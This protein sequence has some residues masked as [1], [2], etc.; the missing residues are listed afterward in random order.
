MNRVGHL[1]DEDGVVCR[2]E[3]G[4]RHIVRDYFMQLFQK[5]NRLRENVI[6]LVPSTITGE[7]NDM[8][9]APFT[10]EEFK[11]ANFSMQAY[12]CPDPDGFNPC[13]YQHFWDTCD[14]E[15]YQAECQWLENGAFPP[16]VNSIYTYLLQPKVI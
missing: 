10:A 5:S 9:T 6:N 16:H 8:L 11:Q 1:E 12:K 3:D 14:H 15:V 2:S 13:F 4:M 7:D